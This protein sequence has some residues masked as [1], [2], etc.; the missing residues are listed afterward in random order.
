LIT[1]KL[2]MARAGRRLP[3]LTD[4]Q[5]VTASLMRIVDNVLGS[6][7]APDQPFM[8]VCNREAPSLLLVLVHC[9]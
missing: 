7:V 5:A 9:R 2:S 4:V 3:Q 1:I 8:E 6:T